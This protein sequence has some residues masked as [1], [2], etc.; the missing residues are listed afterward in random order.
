MHSIIAVNLGVRKARQRA[1]RVLDQ[2]LVRVGG[3]TTWAGRISR[4]G[5][6]VM[7]EQIKEKASRDTLVQLLWQHNHETEVLATVGGR[8]GLLNYNHAT[9][10]KARKPARKKQIN[11][12]VSR[13]I[14]MARASGVWHDVGK[15]TGYFQATLRGKKVSH[16]VRHQTV[17]Y[18][19]LLKFM[20][21]EPISLVNCR[22]DGCWKT[23]RGLE[24]DIIAA[25]VLTHHG[26]P[27]ELEVGEH[28]EYMLTDK[29]G[30]GAAYSSGGKSA[31]DVDLDLTKI[32][33]VWLSEARSSIRRATAKSVVTQQNHALAFYATRLAMMLGDHAVS[34]TDRTDSP[35]QPMPDAVYAK[36]NGDGTPYAPLGKHLTDVAAQAG[37]A[38]YALF[39]HRWARVNRRPESLQKPVPRRFAW[40]ESSESEIA[41]H[42]IGDRDGFFGAVIAETGSG[43]TQGGYRIMHALSRGAPRFTLGLG[44]GALAVQSGAEY[45][46]EIGLLSGEVGIFVGRRF[47]GAARAAEEAANKQEEKLKLEDLSGET[48]I[49]DPCIPDVFRNAGGDGKAF[50]MLA[51]PIA[52][53]TIDH[54]MAAMEADRGSYVMAASRAVTSDLLI[55]EIDSF[56]VRD[57]HAIARL[58]YLV[59]SFGRKVLVSSATMTP[60]IGE[61]LFDAYQ[62][63]YRQ[64]QSVFGG[65]LFGGAFCNV[66]NEVKVAELRG[67]ADGETKNYKNEV[68]MPA[69]NAVLSALSKAAHRRTL[70]IAAISAGKGDIAQA[71]EAI[72][73]EA[74]AL[75]GQHNTSMPDWGGRFFSTGFV[76]FNLVA[77][78][79]KFTLWLMK[80]L[81]RLESEYGVSIKTNCYTSALDSLN[82]K[83]MERRLGVLLNRKTPDW[84]GLKEIE[85]LAKTGKPGVYILA[86]TPI[87]EVGRDYDFD[88]AILEP[89]SDMS[90]IQSGGRVLRHRVEALA[91]QS[92]NV[93]MMDASIRGLMGEAGNPYGS[94]GPGFQQPHP[95]RADSS[96]SPWRNVDGA[97]AD[98]KSVFGAALYSSG[99][100]AGY[101][102]SDPA[103]PADKADRSMVI[104]AHR[105]DGHCSV[106]RFLETE[107]PWRDDS[108]L[109]M[110]FRES[111]NHGNEYIYIATGRKP[112]WR[113]DSDKIDHAEPFMH[114]GVPGENCA[115]Y[116]FA[117]KGLVEK[118]RVYSTKRD[119]SAGFLYSGGLG[120]VL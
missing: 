17:S 30:F 73:H 4:E 5:V 75:A 103:T 66:E 77:Q 69:T 117:P 2:Y 65:R 98:A 16:D 95:L 6:A 14:L 27:N 105:A 49:L 83:E 7:L 112:G 57:L 106:R 88:W 10:G 34:S 25:T 72:A 94:P 40:Q 41:R 63:G 39:E 113:L 97:C 8:R 82:R 42:G 104:A 119:L 26:I 38:A 58:I 96:E 54:I 52:V 87:I 22:R 79:Q 23:E 91:P 19:A 13:V 107:N 28:D 9:S 61:M 3:N 90:I 109:E 18:Y 120:V 118:T 15:A 46:K 74:L 86:T 89:S 50:R 60:E 44:F 51:V 67:N 24:A 43:K 102:L 56:S 78:A 12:F 53:I 45:R 115:A 99:I 62:S 92:P 48:D 70:G 64:Y 55:D 68:L 71:Y 32:G 80:N 116:L 114:A 59:A 11:P 1:A 110:K 108:F 36:S 85:A 37:H 101:R 20:N 33:D 111:E 29:K 100:H 93:L 76:R 81:D 31:V 47:Y 84:T 21:G 35:P